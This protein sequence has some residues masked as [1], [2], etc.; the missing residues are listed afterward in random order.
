M[1]SLAEFW[2]SLLFLFRRRQFDR[3]LEEEMRFHLEM[4]GRESGKVAARR[5]FGNTALLQED[6]RD[7]WGW[8][9]LERVLQ[10][11]RYAM[12][13]LRKA[14]GFTAVVILTLALGI[15]VNTAIFSLVDRLILR[16][17]PFPDSGRLATIF[18]RGSGPTP[19]NSLSYPDYEYYRDHNEIFSGLAA[20][21]DITVNVRFGNDDEAVPGQIVSANYF[22]V[23]Q[24]PPILGRNFRPQEDLV[25]GRDSVVMI[26][27]DLW[28]RR[29]GGD[30]AVLGR[31]VI[32]NGHDFT[33][34]GIVPG[35]FAGLQIDRQSK[36]ELW[37]PI[38]SYPTVIS[39]GAEYDL[40]HYRGD[41]WLSAT[42]RLKPGV[43]Q[44]QAS[45]QIAQLTGQLKTIYRAE[46]FS[47]GKLLGMP[48]PANDSRFLLES[49]QTVTRFLTMLMAVV[50]LVLLIAC[51]NVASLL[52]A[53]GVKRQKEIGVRVALGACR[54]RLAQQLMSEGLLLSLAGG[55][56]GIA[57]TLVVQRFLAAFDSPFPMGVLL[58]DSVDRRVLIFAL[59]LSLLTGILFGLLPLRQ[60]ARLDVTPMLKTEMPGAGRRVFRAR[61]L[62]VVTQ[63]A[64]SVVLLTG[65][66]LFVRTL[67][68]AQ[69]ADVTRDSDKVLLFNLN[70]SGS[71]YTHE[72]GRAFYDSLMERVH[73]IPGVIDAAY[74]MI[75]P[76]GGRRGGT[77]IVPYPGSPPLQVDFNVVSPEYFQTVGIPLVRGRALTGRDREGSAGVAI[78]NEQMARHFWPGE[79]PIGKHF[80]VEGRPKRKVEV[81]GVV[82]DGRFRGYRA[83]IN[84]CIY[85]PVAQS[86]VSSLHLEVRTVRAS[87][88][89]AAVRQRIYELDRDLL[90]A[91]PQTLRAF[92]DAGLGQERLSAALLSGLSI[93]AALIAAIG[94][95]GVMAFTVAQRTR[96]I[97]VRVALG[98]ASGDILRGVMGE[99]LT[100]IAAGLAIG[101]VA[102]A[103]LARLIANL[104][105][106]I[107]ATD[108][109]TYAATAAVLVAAGAVA[110]FIPARRASR[111]DPMVAL[112]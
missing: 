67:R 38:M 57:V 14:P 25:P 99:A 50:G 4:K 3:D 103:L 88:V 55:A 76:F 26:S 74:V 92:R 70:L 63:V 13:T 105:F 62:L 72:Q 21:D 60:A 64:L 20:Y 58:S 56:A 65:A 18:F 35:D 73:G 97:G 104:L 78:V 17:L 36:P 37:T 1:E 107:S 42:G 39:W 81:V 66:G 94:L 87:T 53:R 100:L 86:Y 2:R 98:A 44:G 112:R 22:D 85:V 28:K 29:F 5:R 96:E 54:A 32:I 95:Y 34:I 79:D 33:V 89:A 61:S 111:V 68:N 91:P 71:K 102:A 12:R 6:C 77:D 46:K 101:F 27:Q 11:V 59:A 48:I 30:P 8:R 23:L 108:A 83:T 15:G 47:N 93:L 41:E 19:Y 45:A 40:Q 109:A 80:E 10:D 31:S 106:G 84:P 52:L 49:R 7:A 90:V 75:V 9:A 82:R 51:A 43:S 24:V 16:P 69:A 110:A